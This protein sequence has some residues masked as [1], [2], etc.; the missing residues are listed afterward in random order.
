MAI[1]TSIAATVIGTAATVYSATQTPGK[2]NLPKA[3]VVPKLPETKSVAANAQE[4]DMR[5]RSAGGTILS[6][7]TKNQQQVG[8]ASSSVRKTL[9][10]T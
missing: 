10:G 6:D 9:L 8:D 2:P 5:A 7:Q 1:S 3:P 4:A